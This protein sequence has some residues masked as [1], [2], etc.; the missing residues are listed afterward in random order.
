MIYYKCVVNS[1]EQQDVNRNMIDR[2]RATS[3]IHADAAVISRARE[4]V[5]TAAEQLF[6]EHG[7][8]AVGL[9]DIADALGM[10]HAS[11]YTH[12]PGGKEDLYCEVMER[13]FARHRQHLEQI[14]QTI[15]PPLRRQLRAVSDWLLSQP[16]VSTMRMMQSDMFA[17]APE[18]SKHLMDVAYQG[19]L[20]PIEHLVTS[21]YHRGEVRRTNTGMVAGMLLSSIEAVRSL[22]SIPGYGASDET[23]LDVH[24]YDIIDILIEGIERRP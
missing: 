15:A 21:A 23:P 6:G 20:A 18:R 3:D 16:A 7:Y 2:T 17:I 10:R 1:Q 8:K 24:A 4:R 5:L 11:L 12:F 19:L 9:K 22:R 14:G 13:T